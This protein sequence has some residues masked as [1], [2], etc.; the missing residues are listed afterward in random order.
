M[1]NGLK[2]KIKLKDEMSELQKEFYDLLQ[3]LEIINDLFSNSSYLKIDNFETILFETS[4]PEE[5]NDYQE[6]FE[7]NLMDIE[8][9]I[10]EANRGITKTVT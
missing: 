6:T 8:E 4:Q 2:S 5:S 10:T 7:G 9:S 1:I 3:P